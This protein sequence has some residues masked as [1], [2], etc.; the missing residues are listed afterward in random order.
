MPTAASN[1]IELCYETFGDPD[2]PT[3]LLVMG[4]GAQLLGWPVP[5]C[6]GLVDRGFHVVRYDHR[7]VGLSTWFD[8]HPV[9]LAEAMPL[10]L[11]GEAPEVPY[12]LSDMAADAAGLLDAL[13]VD[14]AHVVGASMGGMV[15]QTLAIEHPE[16]VAS[17][18][19]TRLQEIIGSLRMPA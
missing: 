15:A 16:R 10:L 8:D 11:A 17:L 4:L 19:A 1:G 14:R 9:D 6:E 5:F 7:D 2:D 13:G 12:R 18:G 3:V